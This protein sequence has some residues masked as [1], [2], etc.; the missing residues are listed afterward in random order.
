VAGH[1]LIDA[2]LAAAARQ[3]PAEAV[4]ELTDGLAETY[5]AQRSGGLDPDAAAAAAIAQFGSLD[6]VLSAFV[7]QSPGRRVA[8]ALLRSGPLVGACWAAALIAGHAW[9][10]PIPTPLRVVFGS[11]LVVV[12]ALLAVAATS[13]RSYRRTHAGAA[14]GIALIVLD[15]A[16][17]TAV[18]VAAPGLAWPTAVAGLASFVRMVW[19]TRAVPQLFAH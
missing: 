3:L 10:W 13:R 7:Q 4:D 15:A 16:A 12:V 19:T 9:T 1:H 5:R 17:L 6:L 8:R 11:A 2:Y 18:L 14:G